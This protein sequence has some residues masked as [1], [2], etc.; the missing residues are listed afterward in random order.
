MCTNQQESIVFSWQATSSQSLI[1]LHIKI[2]LRWYTFSLSIPDILKSLTMMFYILFLVLSLN[3]VVFAS[4]G[5][6]HY[7]YRACLNHCQ[8]MNCST[9]LG[10]QEFQVKQSLFEYLFQWSC[11]DECAYECMWKAVDHMQTNGQPVVQFHG[12]TRLI[13]EMRL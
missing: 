11:P 13:S 7:L 8:Q 5:D 1:C 4:P 9:P 12:N 10:L 2:N 3:F 6:R